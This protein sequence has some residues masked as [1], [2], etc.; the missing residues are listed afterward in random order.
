MRNT[1]KIE[2]KIQEEYAQRKRTNV[3][4][5]GVWKLWVEEIGRVWFE[6]N[7]SKAIAY[8][9]GFQLKRT[10]AGLHVMD[11]WVDLPNYRITEDENASCIGETMS[12]K[13]FSVEFSTEEWD[14]MEA[15][16]SQGMTYTTRRGK[17]K[18]C[19]MFPQL[20]N[21]RRNVISQ[22]IMMTFYDLSCVSIANLTVEDFERS[23]I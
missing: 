11:T 14:W 4:L 12:L 1:V 17:S 13:Q 16:L 7:T 3:R 21:L 9:V 19:A 15:I 18:S 2:G 8:C 20:K 10:K 5:R 23:I 22:C 6:G